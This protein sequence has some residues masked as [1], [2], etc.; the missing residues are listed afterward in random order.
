MLGEVV[1]GDE[2]AL[3]RAVILRKSFDGKPLI[4]GVK[5]GLAQMLGEPSLARVLPPLV[6]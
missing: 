3:A 4:P 2:S 6:E 1:G 5:A